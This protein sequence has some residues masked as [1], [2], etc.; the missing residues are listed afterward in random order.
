MNGHLKVKGRPRQR[1]GVNGFRVVVIVYLLRPRAKGPYYLWELCWFFASLFPR[2]PDL[3]KPFI[4]GDFCFQLISLFVLSS[5]SLLK[6][7]HIP[8]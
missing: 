5:L 1:S 4:S 6:H 3:E 7:T 8:Y 2:Y